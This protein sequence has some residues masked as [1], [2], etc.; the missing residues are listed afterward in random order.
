MP[1]PEPRPHKVS[2]EVM[3]PSGI[4]CTPPSFL[5]HECCFH[6]FFYHAGSVLRYGTLFSLDRRNG[7]E[8]ICRHFGAVE[9]DTAVLFSR[10]AQ[11]GKIPVPNDFLVEHSKTPWSPRIK[12]NRTA[13]Q[14]QVI[15]RLLI[16]SSP[17]AIVLGGLF[18]TYDH[19][20]V[21]SALRCRTKPRAQSFN[22]LKTDKGGAYYHRALCSPDVRG[23]VYDG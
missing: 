17:I 11:Q 14:T 19:H 4:S 23:F 10:K 20:D 15:G 6:F 3:R 7:R 21:Y 16:K 5:G 1:K 2:P 13:C 8:K 22:Q 9:P 12:S 18:S